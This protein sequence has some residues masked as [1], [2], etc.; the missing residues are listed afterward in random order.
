MA[1]FKIGLKTLVLLHILPGYS[2]AGNLKI[3]TRSDSYFFDG[4]VDEVAVFDYVLTE[5]QALEIF[6]A[7]STGETADLTS[8]SPVAWYRMGDN[9]TYQAPQIL[10]PENSNK[11][12]VSNYSFSFDGVDDYIDLGSGLDIFQYNIGQSYS[13]S[14]WYKSTTSTSFDTIVNFG[15]NTYKFSL[16]TGLNGTISFSAGNSTLINYVNKWLPTAGVINDGNWHHICIVQDSSS[17]TVDLTAYVDGSSSGSSPS[18]TSAFLETN[19]RIGDGYYSGFEGNIDEVS[20]FN[21]S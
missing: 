11:D 6:N 21:S 8:L 20:K 7:T 16:V 15:S 9:S 1:L 4:K 18:S 13:V 2:Y 3:G 17:N 10:M 5:P 12:K 14:L 19:N